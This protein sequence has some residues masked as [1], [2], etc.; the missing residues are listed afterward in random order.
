MKFPHVTI[1]QHPT[2]THCVWGGDGD[3]GLKYKKQFIHLFL[4]DYEEIIQA[5]SKASV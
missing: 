2:E 3:G 1:V 5:C 4:I